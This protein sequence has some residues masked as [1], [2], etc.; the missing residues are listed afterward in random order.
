MTVEVMGTLLGATI[1]GQ[2]VASAH[3]Q[4]HCPTHNMSAGYLGNSSGAEIVK[5][6]VH[7]QE[8]LSHA[9]SVSLPIQELRCVKNGGKEVV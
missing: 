4:K 6:L 3:S 7:S 9:V 8:Y 5:S 1:Q 2:I